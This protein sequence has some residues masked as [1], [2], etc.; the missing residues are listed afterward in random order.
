MSR[1]LASAAA[2]EFAFAIDDLPAGSKFE[3]LLG[4]GPLVADSHLHAVLERL[5]L[6][7][8]GDE[9]GANVEDEMVSPLVVARPGNELA[10]VSPQIPVGR[11]QPLRA[12]PQTPTLRK[13]IQAQAR[14]RKA[15]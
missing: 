2:I 8:D 14:W 12:Y 10:V 15:S 9:V 11:L 3:P 1:R 13:V 7:R 6:A 4:G 5:P